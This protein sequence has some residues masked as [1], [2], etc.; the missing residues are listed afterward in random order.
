M[1][2]MV[3]GWRAHP[4]YPLIVVANRDEFY[5][6]ATRSAHFWPDHP[7]VFAGRDLE[8]ADR[9][10]WMGIHRSGRFA[11]VTNFREMD[12][13]E[14]AAARSRGELTARFLTTPV[15]LD[16]YLQT[17]HSEG[18]RYKGFNL[19]LREQNRLVHISNRS[20][21]PRVLDEGIYGL[22]NGSLDANWPKVQRAKAMLAAALAK[23]LTPDSLVTLLGDRTPAD[24]S[25]LPTTG[26]DMASEILLSSCFIHSPAYGTRATTVLLVHNDGTIVFLEQNWND[27][28]IVSSREYLRLST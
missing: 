24:I 26:I 21:A 7:D 10:T 25:E 9:G 18:N 6:R 27:K 15:S 1:C 3:F 19:L 17:V 22:S 14:T 20:T 11:A 13:N 5:A 2:L 28:G 12:V 8:A 23:P 16:D 4:D